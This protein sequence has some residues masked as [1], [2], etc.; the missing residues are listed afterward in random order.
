MQLL[1]SEGL[2][3][4]G[5]EFVPAAVVRA[6]TS[7]Q[8]VGAYDQTLQHIVD[9]G[10]GVICNSNTWGA[11]T[12]PYG[13][14]RW[15]SSGAFGHGGAQCA[16]AMCDPE[17]RLAVAWAANGFCG[18]AQHQRRNRMLQDALYRDLGFADQ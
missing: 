15:S 1:L 7:R 13:F 3:E 8:R 14:G 16:L 12:V 11:D 2:T 18:E 4:D 6:M 9:F 17:R 10:L 5:R